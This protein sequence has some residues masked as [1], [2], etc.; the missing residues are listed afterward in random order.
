MDTI[1]ALGSGD[2]V[3]S[4]QP[5]RRMAR[6]TDAAWTRAELA[7]IGNEDIKALSAGEK[8]PGKP[9]ED[10][11]DQVVDGEFLIKK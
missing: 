4:I 10:G 9:S 8:G 11:Q 6:Q 5:L 7:D 3:S 2:K 1:D